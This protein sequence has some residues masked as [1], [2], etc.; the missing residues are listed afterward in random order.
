MRDLTDQ[1]VRRQHRP[2]VRARPRRSS[3]SWSTRACAFVTTSAGRPDAS[4]PRQLKDG[5]PH[6]LPRRPD[7]GRGAEG[8]RRRGRRS[9]RRGRRGRRVQEP[10][11][12]GDHGAA[13][14]RRAPR[15]TCRSSPPAASATGA[16]MAAAFA[17]GAEGVQMGTRMV[18]AAES[19]VHD[20]WKQAI[21]AAAETDTVFL[22]RF[23]RPG[24]RALRTARTTELE[25]A[26]PRRHSR[27]S[28]RRWT[29]TSA[30]TW[31]PR[32]R[33]AARSWGASTRCG[34]WPTSSTTRCGSWWPRRGPWRGSLRRSESHQ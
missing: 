2:A 16:T 12:R 34:R 14:A 1:P 11:R 28:A 29:S 31:R 6:R 21:V 19:P 4:T 30:V 9:R 18:S 25:R 5:R 22:N 32:S 15:S 7:A 33:S 17:L 27:C 26:G 23:S 8:G 20:N 13:A 3:S 10:S 24:L